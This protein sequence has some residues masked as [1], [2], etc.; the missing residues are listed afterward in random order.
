[1]SE[2]RSDG[3]VLFVWSP[4]GYAVRELE[5][6]PPQLGHELEDDGRTLV[7]TKLGASPFPGD[8]RRCAYTSGR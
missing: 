6:E 8:P 7:V 4:A 1:M 3:Y 5:G 2:R